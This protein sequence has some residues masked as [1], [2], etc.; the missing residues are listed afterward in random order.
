M[1]YEPLD[2]P[3][4]WVYTPTVW[5]DDRGT[6]QELV[7][8][9][10]F[11]DATGA[12]LTVAQVNCSVSHRGVLRGVHFAQTPPGQA[13]YV[14]C[15][16][17]AV[18]DVIVDVRVGSPTFG[19][20][21]SVLLDDAERKATYLAE[22]LGHAFLSLEDDST[23]VYL[24]STAYNPGVEHEVD[25]LDPELGIEW[26][27]TDRAG[28]RLEVLRSPKDMAAPSVSTAAARDLLPRFEVNRHSVVPASAAR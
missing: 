5:A 8:D 16:R 6:F 4:A 11:T 26:P 10:P 24:C 15:V 28:R 18:L 2:V 9:A 21:T 25:A 22:G 14:T 3:G 7:R 1:S 27:T 19:R 12:A 13:K 20:W 23:V 17:G